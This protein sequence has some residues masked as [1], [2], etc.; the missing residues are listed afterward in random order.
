MVP[1]S[2]SMRRL[3]FLLLERVLLPLAM[4]PWRAWMRSWRMHGPDPTMLAELA[5]RPRVIVMIFHGT[6]VEGLA[7]TAMW[8]P[9]G[10]H[11]VVLTTPSLD[12]QFAVAML[13]RFTVR[14]A[15]LVQ[16]ERGAE[17]AREFI[18]RVAAGDIGCILVD[19]PRGPRG[20][21]KSGVARTVAAAGAEVVAAGLA[22]SSGFH[23]N[24]W[25]RTYLPAPF[26]Q[27]H[28]RFRLLGCAPDG[29]TIQSAMDAVTGEALAAAK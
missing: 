6:L 22:A 25:D 1:G 23:F 10:R 8:K 18:A 27:V 11:W 5:K 9:Y 29:A 19:G 14:C 26:A 15:P 7:Q 3:R 21:V 17:A 28:V 4:L 20:V 24:S 12:G 16:G 13:D 2:K